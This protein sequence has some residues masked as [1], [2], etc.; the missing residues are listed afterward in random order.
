[1]L[2]SLSLVKGAD[3]RRRG[4]VLLETAVGLIGDRHLDKACLQSR[5][6]VGFTEMLDIL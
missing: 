5:L 1:M 3:T 6:K 4:P 2:A